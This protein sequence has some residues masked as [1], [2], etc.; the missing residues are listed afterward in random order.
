MAIMIRTAEG[1]AET[2][3]SF[4]ELREKILA[5]ARTATEEEPL[6]LTAEVEAGEYIL[7]EPFVLSAKETPALKNIRVTL[8]AAQGARPV[9]AAWH[10]VKGPFERVEGKPYYR[11][12]L[13]KDENGEYPRFHDLYYKGKRMKLASSPTW[14]NMES[15]TKEERGPGGIDFTGIYMPLDFFA[16]IERRGLYCP[17]EIAR[18]AAQSESECTEMRMFVQWE[19]FTLRVTGVDLSD[20]KEIEGKTYAL[21]TFD[22]N[23]VPFFVHGMHRANN[24][25]G[26]VTFFQNDVAF[27]TEENS[28]VCDW[29]NGYLYFI[30]DEPKEGMLMRPA[31]DSLFVLEEISGFTVEGLDF[32]GVS[33][34]FVCDNGYYAQLFNLERRQ[35]NLMGDRLRHAAI[36][37]VATRRLTV[38]NCTFRGI[39]CNGVLLCDRTVAATVCDSRF[40]DVAMSGIS[41]GNPFGT[42]SDPKKNLNICISVVNNY[43]EHIAYEY[44]NATAIYLGLC[45]G[46]TVSHNTI[47]GCGY[48]GISAG[49]NY[50]DANF[51]LGEKVNLRDVEISYNRV[52]DFM[53][54]CRDGGAYYVAGG[55]AA[56]RYAKRFNRIH[57]NFASLEVLGNGDTMGYYLDGSSSHWELT[58]NVVDKCRMPLYTQYN[59][60]CQYSH[61]CTID[62]FYSTTEVNSGNNRPH[63][64]VYM[65]NCVVV[66]DLEELLS[67][68]PEARS[69]VDGAGYREE[70]AC[71]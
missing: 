10:P 45:D 14:I 2:A 12:R 43:L 65:T 50:S 15:L 49:C 71:K 29:K 36:V 52:S 34:S 16:P 6:S 62:G 4:A 67:Q 68:Y 26:R 25:M 23:F 18:Q 51:E 59:I 44:S 30:A 32:T 39:G 33:S 70:E 53:E 21:V 61:H 9:I 11:C 46:A 1:A 24:M 41:V 7:K 69:I 35:N 57:H 27:L 40:L 66:P 19:Q 58:D 37:G 22:E 64:D 63:H 48:S 5:A 17:I 38:K 60:P 8:K 13:E 28:F 42:W 3:A 47:K 56:L 31:L 20:T 55:N 54:V